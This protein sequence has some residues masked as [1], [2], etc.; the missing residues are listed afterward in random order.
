MKIVFLA[1]CPWERPAKIAFAL[2]K[3]GFTVILVYL[4]EPVNFDLQKYFNFAIKAQNSA[5]AV[6]IV[7][8]LRADIVH[9]FSAC[10]DQTALDFFR[11]KSGKA[12]Y[13]YKDCF[14]NLINVDVGTPILQ[15]QRFC[16][17][18]ADALCCRDLQ[19]SRYCQVN[20]I[21]LNT[22]RILFMDYCWGIEIP[23][24]NVGHCDEVHT[25]IAGNFS[26]EIEEP[27]RK[28]SGYIHNV[29]ALVGNGIHVHM[30]LFR[31]YERSIKMANDKRFEEYF[32]LS[33]SSKLFHIHSPVPMTEFNIE[34]SQFHFGLL[35]FQGALFRDIGINSQINGALAVGMATRV[36][37][38][39]EA[40]LE[41]IITPETKFAY[42]ALNNCGLAVAA[43]PDLFLKGNMRE[44]LLDRINSGRNARVD[45]ARSKFS[46]HN[47][48]SK[49]VEFYQR[50]A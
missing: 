20:N 31:G 29:R 6:A 37:D 48:I 49:L 25:V 46:I 4:L 21:N 5:E 45:A 41:T 16:I 22:P 47:N 38:Y 17:E 27:H 19:L 14:E 43:V 32:E 44:L 7:H 33:N 42:R 15:G 18:N 24:K 13:D 2:R 1:H 39:I 12:I 10:V 35:I 36:F 40:G 26:S 34:I 3:I 50:V 28:D 23:R 11:L 30:Y 9:V 8:R